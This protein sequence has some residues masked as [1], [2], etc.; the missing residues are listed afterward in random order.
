[1]ENWDELNEGFAKTEAE[2]DAAAAV[3]DGIKAEVTEHKD[4]S[5]AHSAEHITYSGAVAGAGDIKG[6]VDSVKQ[7]L[8]TAVMAGDSSVA[9]DQASIDVEGVKHPSLKARIDYDVVTLSEQLADTAKKA[10]YEKAKFPILKPT[11]NKTPLVSFVFDDGYIYEYT[12]TKRYFEDV[13]VNRSLAIIADDQYRFGVNNNFMTTAQIL[14]LQALGTEILSHTKRHS[15]LNVLSD[16]DLYD[17]IVN[18][19]SYLENEGFDV[20]SIVY[21]LVQYS[22]ERIFRYAKEVYRSGIAVSGGINTGMLKQMNVSRLS[23]TSRGDTP[24][25]LSDYKSKVDEAIASNGWLVFMCH[26]SEYH[27]NEFNSLDNFPLLIE[28]IQSLNVPIVTV[29]EA[30]DVVGNKLEISKDYYSS[31]KEFVV[32][33]DG[34]VKIGDLTTDELKVVKINVLDP[35]TINASSPPASFPGGVSTT[36]FTSAHGITGFPGNA[37]TLVTHRESYAGDYIWQE[38]RGLGT[39]YMVARYYNTTTNAWT[40]LSTQ[41]PTTEK[42]TTLSPASITIS[43]HPGLFPLGTSKVVF[44]TVNPGSGFPAGWNYG[45]LTTHRDDI[46][47][48]YA[49]QEWRGTGSTDIWI[50]F[51]S[52]GV[53]TAF[54]TRS[55]R[56]GVTANRPANSAVGQ[57]YYDTT[58]GKP[59]WFDGTVWNESM[60]KFV[61]VPTSTSTPG[62]TGNWSADAS[63]MYICYA[64]N[65]WRR[66]SLSSW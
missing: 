63:Y 28:Y 19:K 12:Q 55:P 2:L 36:I 58:L 47:N 21:P 1:M 6:A 34:L 54:V 11:R 52:N 13:G 53:W 33:S 46:S 62:N 61:S 44:T 60:S 49:W 4:S 23:Y 48:D 43:T 15:R 9:A 16:E 5:A 57:N 3:S 31:V 17:D 25:T 45:T 18:S 10:Q 14:E 51:F 38:W 20:E 59:I 39:N 30:L 8:D 37:G 32:S 50:R 64:P 56:S 40:E 41:M 24:P 65:S 27:L 26:G 35:T 7:Q 29:K 22:D 66:V 42:I